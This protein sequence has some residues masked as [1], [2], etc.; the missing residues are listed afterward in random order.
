MCVLVYVCCRCVT[1]WITK[2]C[3]TWGSGGFCCKISLDELETQVLQDC[4]ESLQRLIL[5][6]EA[7]RRPWDSM[8]P[9]CI[10]GIASWLNALSNNSNILLWLWWPWKIAKPTDQEVNVIQLALRSISET[11]ISQHVT[12]KKGN[13][14]LYKEPP[15]NQ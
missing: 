15:G 14:D 2:R 12:K 1:S 8:I 9:Y 11:P 6:S 7:A 10:R 13:A 3:N 5:A 4:W